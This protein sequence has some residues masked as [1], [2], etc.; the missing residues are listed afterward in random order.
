MTEELNNFIAENKRDIEEALIK[1]L[2]TSSLSKAVR[3]ND[4][5]RYAVFPGGKRLRPILSLLASDLVGLR[6]EQGLLIASAVEFFHSSSLIL[7]DLPSMD[8]ANLRRKRESLHIV[9]GESVALL[10]SVA[11]LNHS[12]ALLTEAAKFSKNVCASNKLIGE[13]ARCIGTDGMIGGQVV[14]LEMK[15]DSADFQTLVYRDLKTVAL[16][17]LM[18][19]AGALA[20]GAD[21]ESVSALREF[22]ECFGKAYQVCDDLID[23]LESDLTGKPSGQDTRHFRVTAVSNLGEQ[24]AIGLAKQLIEHGT[25]RLTEQFGNRREV[26]LLS[27]VAQMIMDRIINFKPRI[28]AV[29]TNVSHSANKSI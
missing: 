19:T 6:R 2:P 1:N 20:Q 14:D 27:D 13:A 22:G 23:C 21:D 10:A 7:D 18:M 5:L 11:L 25:M 16:M 17:R 4:A 24:E 29:N 26:S 15:T 12:Y 9:F 3:L 8:D 28:F